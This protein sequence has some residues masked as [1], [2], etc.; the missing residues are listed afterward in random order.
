M[1]KVTRDQPV[2]KDRLMLLLQVYGSSTFWLTILDAFYQSLVC[3]FIPYLV[4]PCV[5]DLLH[6][7]LLSFNHSRYCLLLCDHSSEYDCLLLRGVCRV[8]RWGAGLRIARQR[9]RSPHHLTAPGHREPHPGQ[10]IMFTSRSYT[11]CMHEQ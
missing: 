4:R 7:E 9:V 2:N 8:R 6:H 11:E 5:V 10:C 1:K 3:F